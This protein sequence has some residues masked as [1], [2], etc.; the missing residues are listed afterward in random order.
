MTFQQYSYSLQ[1]LSI[2]TWSLFPEVNVE[3]G[4]ND[5]SFVK[6]GYK[7]SFFFCLIVLG[8]IVKCGK[9]L[10][11]TYDFQQAPLS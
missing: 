9:L 4:I 10:L 11:I 5:V 6:W 2:E 8:I 7:T 3:L 1:S